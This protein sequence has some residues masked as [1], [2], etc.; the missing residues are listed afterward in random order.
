MLLRTLGTKFAQMGL[1]A[2]Q[3]SRIEAN[4]HP[5]RISSMLPVE[6]DA[7]EVGPEDVAL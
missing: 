7:I 6:A 4:R 2:A 5:M 1:T 3:P